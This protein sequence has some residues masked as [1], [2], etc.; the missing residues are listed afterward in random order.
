MDQIFASY[1]GTVHDAMREA[2]VD[3]GIL[4][5]EKGFFAA[6]RRLWHRRKSP[7]K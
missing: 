2:A 1:G 6:W 4:S 7:E 3:R 5:E